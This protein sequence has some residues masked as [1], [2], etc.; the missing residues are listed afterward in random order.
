MIAAP[1]APWSDGPVRRRPPLPGLATSG[2]LAAL[3]LV[4]AGVRPAGVRAQDEGPFGC[5]IRAILLEENEI[6]RR[7]YD[8]IRKGLEQ[9]QL[10]RI[11]LE[12]A[13]GP[14]EANKIYERLASSPPPLL[15]V[16]GRDAEASLGAHFATVPRVYVDTAW[17]V[18][19]APLPPDPDVR[20][21]A[22]IV[23]GEVSAAHVAEA[24]RELDLRS[25]RPVARLS[26]IDPDDA[27]Q[28]VARRLGDAAGFRPAFAPADGNPQV[29]LDLGVGAGEHRQKLSRLVTAAEKERVPLV[30]DDRSAWGRGAAVVVMPDAFLLGRAAA[31]EGR[32]LLL[33]DRTRVLRRTVGAFEVGVDLG[34]AAREGLDVPLGFLA[35]ADMIR[36]GPARPSPEGGR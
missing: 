15:F 7:V 4:G 21:P 26:W 16:L 12:L 2:L 24:L 25:S 3:V 18:N 30:S 10:P 9:A 28:A 6:L 22:A 14:R 8:G 29:L 34:A 11:C 13:S 31:E 17:L 20:P 33:E 19:G 5:P 23:R 35:R 1:P 36:R 27:L 32:R